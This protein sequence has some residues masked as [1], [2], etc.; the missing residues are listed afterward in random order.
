MKQAVQISVPPLPKSNTVIIERGLVVIKRTSIGA[1]FSDVLRREVKE[2]PELPS[3]LP[4]LLF[5]LLC[6]GN[7]YRR[8]DKFYEVARLV[9]DRM[10]DR[11]EVLDDS[12]GEDHTVVRS[13][14]GR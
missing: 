7:I 3:A 8:P 1:K 13:I 10:A 4:D 9:Q 2:L 12:V 5:G 14:I 6:G 11:M